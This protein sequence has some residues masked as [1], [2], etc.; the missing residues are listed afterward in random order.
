MR[1]RVPGSGTFLRSRGDVSYAHIRKYLVK[2]MDQFFVLRILH[3]G[4]G[5]LN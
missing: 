4:V 5:V 2:T 3:I 1:D